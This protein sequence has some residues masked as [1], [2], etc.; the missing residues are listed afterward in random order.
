MPAIIATLKNDILDIPNT[1]YFQDW[2]AAL[3]FYKNNR[4]NLI[5]DQ[6]A[7]LPEDLEW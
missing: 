3:D 4:Q 5:L 6:N 2:K 7:I 1:F